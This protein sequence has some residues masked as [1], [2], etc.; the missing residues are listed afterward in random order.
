MDNS[1]YARNKILGGGAL[2][3]SY[4]SA[5][6][7]PVIYSKPETFKND[8]AHEFMHILTPLNLHSEIIHTFN[9]AN[10]TA[11]EH[12]WL[13]E[14][15]TEWSS[16]IMQ[17]RSGLI[18]TDEYMDVISSNLITNDQFDQN[19]SLSKMSTDA[20]SKD[21]LEDFLNFY[22]RGSVT[23]ALL[24]I[25]LLELSGGN[26]GLRELFIELLDKYGKYKPFPEEE[27]FDIIVQ[28]TYPEIEQFINDYI[29]GAEL[30]PYEEYFYKLGYEY[31]YEKPSDDTRP[32]LGIDIGVNENGELFIV[33]VRD[34]KEDKGLKA[35]DVI[36]KLLGEDLTLQSIRN[37]LGEAYKL[38]IGDT[39]DLVV[40]RNDEEVEVIET[41]K[42]RVNR[43]IFESVEELT[44]E[45]KLLREAW[46]KNL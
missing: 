43:H 13:Y 36:L 41:L 11:S 40:R 30:M 32:T 12:I 6:V 25:R 22:N 38:P 42:E 33:S 29:K 31:I 34:E 46:S 2:E 45:Q 23:A 20:Y 24:D 7:Y 21:V 14:G 4:S 15:V 37:L 10:P 9:F 26:Y 19:I 8:M 44:E 1:A 18:T 16:N 17:L 35:G 39:C 5:Y 28:M 3:H 27:F